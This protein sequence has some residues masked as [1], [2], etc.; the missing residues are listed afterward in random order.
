M[1]CPKCKKPMRIVKQEGK[2][3]LY[4]CPDCG[5]TTLIQ[6]NADIVPKRQNWERDNYGKGAKD[7]KP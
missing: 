1:D 6:E 5:H 3:T 7:E 2:M 4:K